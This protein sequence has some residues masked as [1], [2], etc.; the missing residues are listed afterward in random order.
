MSYETQYAARMK[1][2]VEHA[3]K[4]P[5]AIERRR[6]EALA[7]EQAEA[8]L[9]AAYPGGITTDNA[10]EVLAFQRERIAARKTELG[11]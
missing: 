7:A 8:D 1:M 11:V 2:K 6:L 4:S 10:T 5:E 9:N 3:M